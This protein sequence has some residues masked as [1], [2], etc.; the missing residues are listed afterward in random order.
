MEIVRTL[1][2]PYGLNIEDIK[3]KFGTDLGPFNLHHI[4]KIQT[5]RK[6]WDRARGINLGSIQSFHEENIIRISNS[7]YRLGFKVMNLIF[8]TNLGQLILKNI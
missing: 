4:S 1:D 7:S 2:G 6:T 3:L 5:N 8:G